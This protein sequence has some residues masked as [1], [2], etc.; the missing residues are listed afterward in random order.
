[1]FDKLQ[2][3]NRLND[4]GSWP[5]LRSHPL[6]TER[7]AD[8][9][10]RLPRGVA[11][12]PAPSLEHVM[13]AA[14]ARVL[15]RPGVDVLRQWAVQPRSTSFG[16]QTQT[17]QV[18]QLYAATLSAVQLR[19]WAEA[20]EMSGRL[21]VATADR[22]STRLN[23]SH[24]VISYAVFCLKKKKTQKRPSSNAAAIQLLPSRSCRV[25]RDESVCLVMAPGPNT[26][27][28][29]LCMGG[30]DCCVVTYHPY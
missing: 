27:L 3:A 15:S 9:H 18:A 11:P 13:M 10:S 4:N 20:R 5:Y 12:A 19:D 14:R 26:S 22:K 17:Q 28:F 16:S 7:M 2:Q 25:R 6:T 29:L 1:M 30:M 24:L 23:S 21:Q 8:M